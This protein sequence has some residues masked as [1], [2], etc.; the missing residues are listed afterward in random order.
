MDDWGLF[1][2]WWKE[3]DGLTIVVYRSFLLVVLK[4]ESLAL[5]VLL[6]HCIPASSS[7]TSRE[8]L[9]VV[10]LVADNTLKTKANS[11]APAY[12]Q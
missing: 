4:L 10:A 5:V 3:G 12:P 8:P 7:V 2:M 6:V 1:M 9:Q 11:S